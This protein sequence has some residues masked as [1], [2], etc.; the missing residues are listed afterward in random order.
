MFVQDLSDT[1]ERVLIEHSST[2]LGFPG[3]LPQHRYLR[4]IR[5]AVNYILD[6]NSEHYETLYSMMPEKQRSVFLAIAAERRVKE[7][8]G[9]LFVQKYRLP[10]V[11]SV[12][13][14]VKGLMEKDFVTKDQEAYYVYD[15][16]FQLWLER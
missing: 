15:H 3:F 16:F 5:N 4:V 2:G 8:S 11:S 13:S 6:L 14:A 9:G 10:S 1:L 12:V 7:I